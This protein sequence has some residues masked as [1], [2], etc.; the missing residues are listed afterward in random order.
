MNSDEQPKIIVQCDDASHGLKRPIV[1]VTAF[2]Y[3]SPLGTKPLDS[4]AWQ[5]SVGPRLTRNRRMNHVPLRRLDSGAKR[6]EAFDYMHSDSDG[7]KWITYDF[8]C[9]KCSA[10]Q[11]WQAAKLFPAL[12]KTLQVGRSSVTLAELSSIVKGISGLYR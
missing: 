5:E 11:S 7:E 6:A 2:V 8:E 4:M 9:R 3:T 1:N 10:K 12:T